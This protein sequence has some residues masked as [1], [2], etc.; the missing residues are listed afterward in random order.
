MASLRELARDDRDDEE[1]EERDERGEGGPEVGEARLNEMT[2]LVRSFAKTRRTSDS[3]KGEMR[4]M[5]LTSHIPLM[6]ETMNASFGVNA[7]D[8]SSSIGFDRTGTADGGIFARGSAG[9]ACACVAWA[10]EA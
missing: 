4:A 2:P 9:G 1:K 8:M 10:A 6:R 5:D 3:G 7:K